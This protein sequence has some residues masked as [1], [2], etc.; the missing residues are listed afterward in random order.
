MAEAIAM[1]ATTEQERITLRVIIARDDK[2]NQWKECPCGWFYMGARCPDKDCKEW[3]KVNGTKRV[4]LTAHCDED[5]S[6]HFGREMG[7]EG[8]ALRNF[9]HW[10]YELSFDA[11]VNMETGDVTLL[12]V[13]GH[14]ISPTKG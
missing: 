2:K 1:K 4:T 11:D 6:Y 8:D 12:T 9:A 10:G 13:D 7:L 14:K 3:T 5:S